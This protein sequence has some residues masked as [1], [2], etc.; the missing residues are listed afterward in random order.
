MDRKDREKNRQ[1]IEGEE[2]KRLGAQYQLEKQRL[3]E[4][5]NAEARQLM[6]ENLKQ[7]DDVKKMREIH[8]LQAEV[9]G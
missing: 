5:R 6:A 9:K 8:K 1:Q 2:L 3:D 7:I 4:I